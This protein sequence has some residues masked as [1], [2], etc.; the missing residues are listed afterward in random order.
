MYTKSGNAEAHEKAEARTEI[1]VRQLRG[2]YT[3][4]KAKRERIPAKRGRR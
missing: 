2:V 4:I 1:L 3:F